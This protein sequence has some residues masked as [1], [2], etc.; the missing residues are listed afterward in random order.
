M[1]KGAS[2][3][4]AGISFDKKKFANDFSR[5]KVIVS[6]MRREKA[7][8]RKMILACWRVKKLNQ[9]KRQCLSRRGN[10]RQRHLT[11]TAVEG[12]NVF[13]GANQSALVVNEENEKEEDGP[14][15]AKKELNRQIERDAIFRKKYSIHVSGTN[16]P[17]PLKT[18][19]ELSSRYGCES[20]LLRNLAELG[21]KEPTPIQRQA[22][23]VLLSGRECFACAPTGSGKTL[24]FL[25]PMLMKLKH[26]SKDGIRTVI[27]CPTRE[28]AL[29]TTRECKKLAKGNKFRI[30]L[31]KK[32]LVRSADLSKFSCDVLISTPLRLRLAIR[33]KKIDLSRYDTTEPFEL[34]ELCTGDMPY[35]QLLIMVEY[36]VLDEADKLFEVGSLLKQIDPVVKACS[37]PSIIRSLFSAT[38]PDFVEE[39]AR[40]IMHDAVRV[41]IGRKNTA[42]ESIKQKLIFAG[43]EEG[44][45]LALRQSFAESLNPPVLIFLQSK[46][47][48]K[49]L[50]EELAFENIRVGVI[51]SDLS[52]TQRENAVDDFRAGK[53]WVLI[54]T[55]VIA[56][57][58]DFKGVNCVINYDFPDSAAAYIH[59]IGRSGRAGRSGEAI[60]LYTE[61]DIPFLR[62]IANVMAAS[63]CEVPSWITALRKLKGKKH[64]PRRDSISTK[65]KD[66][67]E[68]KLKGK[69]YRPRRVSISTKP[70]DEDE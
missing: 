1:E 13:K 17:S 32:E 67:V 3:L 42:S 56:R 45:L 63:G 65:P 5:F 18:F 31:M 40:S 48:A 55:D 2:F 27:M 39:L 9:R 60:S 28:L 58:M 7:I 36:L 46:E 54:A 30:K 66:E 20:Y 69:K 26:A 15:K 33:K 41:I 44:K 51:H 10:G 50:Y 53:T 59:R 37:N 16:V 11:T 12:F 49:E 52:Q 57:G 47:R 14:S 38:L 35:I 21:Y 25:C 64:R 4:F 19:A 68:R 43:S 24:A 61:D 23:P 29:Q 34:E 70:K 6:L 22:I 62:N 8:I